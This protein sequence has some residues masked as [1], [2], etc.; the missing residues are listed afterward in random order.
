MA[1]GADSERVFGPGTL[2]WVAVAALIALAF[3]GLVFAAGL[4]LGGLFASDEE[5]AVHLGGHEAPAFADLG[6][7]ADIVEEAGVPCPSPSA[8]ADPYADYAPDQVY[9]PTEAV[10]CLSDDGS[11]VLFL[12]PS[13]VDRIDVYEQGVFQEVACLGVS[14][15]GQEIAHS[16]AG[17]N[18]RVTSVGTDQVRRLA[19]HFAGKVVEEPLS[20]FPQY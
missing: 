6:G 17:A 12:Y 3:G 10:R 19:E 8:I 14:T 9:P 16:V 7:L 13:S 5:P 15:S 20:C 11:V 18:W 1:R 2:G 4:V